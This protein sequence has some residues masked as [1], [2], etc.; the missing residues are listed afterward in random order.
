MCF[1]VVIQTQSGTMHNQVALLFHEKDASFLLQTGW[2][3]QRSSSAN[4]SAWWCLSEK[5]SFYTTAV[6]KAYLKSCRL[7]VHF[8]QKRKASSVQNPPGG[9]F[10]VC[11]GL[12]KPQK[13]LLWVWNSCKAGAV[14]TNG[15]PS[16][17][18]QGKVTCRPLDSSVYVALRRCAE[19]IRGLH[20]RC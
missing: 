18:V 15:G 17:G 20:A 2:C 4:R 19:I 8:A 10:I 11:G 6:L 5:K 7:H 3:F 9:A 1:F 13:G 16:W 12:E 14:G